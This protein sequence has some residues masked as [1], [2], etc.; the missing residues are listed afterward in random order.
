MN[1][2]ILDVSQ[3]KFQAEVIQESHQ[4]PVIVDFWAPWCGPCRMLAPVV[5]KLNEEW[6]GA[7][8]V[9]KLDIDESPV[10]AGKLGIRGV[11]TVMVFKNGQKVAQH[12]GLTNRDK[13]VQL[14]GL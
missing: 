14:L 5:E 12:V 13:L 8:K 2:T 4:R 1:A 6:N 3:A 11:P 7:V 10:T 9:G